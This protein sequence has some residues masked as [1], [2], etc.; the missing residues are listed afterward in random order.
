MLLRR[1]L[2][3]FNVFIGNHNNFL[4]IIVSVKTHFSIKVKFL[5]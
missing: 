5:C 4:L 1:K 3:I 2:K